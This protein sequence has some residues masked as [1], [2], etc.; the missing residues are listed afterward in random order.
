[1]ARLDYGSAAD[2]WRINMGWRRRQRRDQLGFVL[3]V[4][5]GT[6]SRGENPGDA[7]EDADLAGARTLRVI[8]FVEDRRNCLL[9]ELEE[10]AS[11]RVLAS[12]QAALK[13]AIQVVFQLEDSELAAEPL[14]SR[15]DQR[16]LLF[17]EAAEGG[18][19]VLRR[20]L[21]EPDALA[22]VAREALSLCHFDPDSGSDLGQAPG[23]RERCE[24]ACYDCLL[25]YGNQPDHPLLDRKEIKPLLEYLARATV[26][27]SPAAAGRSA[28]LDALLRLTGSELERRWLLLLEQNGHRLP[29]SAQEAVPACRTRPD[30]LYD[31]KVAVYIDGPVHQYSERHQRDV[32]QT[33]A[34]EDRGFTV[35]RF[36]DEATW[37]ELVGRYPNVFGPARAVRSPEPTPPERATAPAAGFEMDLYPPEWQSLM[38]ALSREPG[39]SVEP[40]EDV[41]SPGQP[42]GGVVGQS[43]AVVRRD[44]RVLYLIDPAHPR[45][46]DVLRALSTVG[47]ALKIDPTAPDARQRVLTELEAQS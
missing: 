33:E 39:L 34:M 24:A 36:T 25:S 1:L 30:F 31:G 32:T 11:E 40:G 7:D 28:H 43:C 37:G 22:R 45:A 3:D 23:A 19:G 17:Y 46:D 15:D 13:T 12:L 47:R 20:L 8:P 27:S 9:L 10:D 4:D 38:E 21:D 44:G 14:P 26:L 5:R 41:M 2:V 18:A 6:W 29:A 42:E 35:L 16:L